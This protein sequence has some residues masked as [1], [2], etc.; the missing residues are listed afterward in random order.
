MNEMVLA[1]RAVD[2]RSL[3]MLVLDIL[4]RCL[5]TRLASGTW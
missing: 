1:N 2:W 4:R 3:K 5:Q